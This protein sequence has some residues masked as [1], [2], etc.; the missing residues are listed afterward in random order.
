MSAEKP[1]ASTPFINGDVSWNP[2]GLDGGQGE[3]D[4]FALF[5]GFVVV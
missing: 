4:N 2:L 1:L 5:F 3:T